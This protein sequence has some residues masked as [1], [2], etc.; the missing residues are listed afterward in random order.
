MLEVELKSKDLKKYV[1][2][3]LGKNKN[4]SIYDEELN[5]ITDIHIDGLDFFNE[6]TDMTIYDLIFFKNL[7]MCYLSDMKISKNEV[8]IL[9]N[10]NG[11]NSLQL[12][13]CVIEED[14]HIVL[15]IEL[16]V[17][18]ECS[19]VKISTYTKMNEL[20]KLCIINCNNVDIKGISKLT[21][22]KKIFLQNLEFDNIDEILNLKN[23]K[24]LNLN[25]SKIKSLEKIYKNTE[26]EIEHQDNNFLYDSEF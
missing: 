6:Q 8:N 17:I 24:N 2:I 26:L 1:C 22:L 11:L 18:E 10:I 9:N 13:N 19:N 20:E 7:K 14:I 23:L 25:G 21:N 3:K 12:N 5:K 16:L 15:P 4:D